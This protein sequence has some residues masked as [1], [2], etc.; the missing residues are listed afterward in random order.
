MGNAKFCGVGQKCYGNGAGIG[1]IHSQSMEV[2]QLTDCFLKGFSAANQVSIRPPQRR[3]IDRRF[4][5]G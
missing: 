3:Q 5:Q 4:T 2:I 1:A